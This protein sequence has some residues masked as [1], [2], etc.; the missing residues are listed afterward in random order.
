MELATLISK[1]RADYANDLNGAVTWLKGSVKL[2]VRAEA[3]IGSQDDGEQTS[4]E[5]GQDDDSKT[6]QPAEAAEQM[7]TEASQGANETTTSRVHLTYHR[8]RVGNPRHQTYN[9]ITLV[10]PGWR[11]LSVPPPATT[12]KFSVRQLQKALDEYEIYQVN[13]GTIVTFYW[14]EPAGKWCMG[15]TNGWDISDY[16]W[17]CD[18][19]YS[20]AFSAVAAK[21][22]FNINALNKD[23]C[24]TIGFRHHGFHPLMTDPERVWLIRAYDP[25]TY[26]VVTGVPGL[27]EQRPYELPKMLR[28][29]ARGL[30][31]S[32]DRYIST[33][34]PEYGLIFRSKT[35][36]SPNYL[37]ESAL[38]TK[39]RNFCYHLPRELGL[40]HTTRMKYSTLRAY[41]GNEH[42]LFLRLFPQFSSEFLRY[43]TAIRETRD[44]IMDELRRRDPVGL[45]TN[46]IGYAVYRTLSA[47]GFNAFSSDAGQIIHDY[48]LDKSNLGLFH[49]AFNNALDT[50]FAHE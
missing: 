1:L 30:Q 38:L 42:K 17:L 13:D 23:L 36:A 41:M 44:R 12:T 47:N 39:I 14:Y 21:S 19:T 29:M 7:G 25:K 26:S 8:S 22:G 24:Y 4:A 27:E 49:N 28:V 32:V 9:G 35:G 10:Y 33:K 15:S 31:R 45:K 16:K 5:A 37:L 18:L 50:S 20:E 40:D 34:R 43:D 11:V 3:H 48:L 46:D 2:H 6:E